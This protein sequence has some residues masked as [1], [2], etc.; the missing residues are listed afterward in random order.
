[1]IIS[2]DG[3]VLYSHLE[4]QEFTAWYVNAFSAI[5][6]IDLLKLYILFHIVF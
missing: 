5:R 4:L 2:S 3:K 1:M 6:K